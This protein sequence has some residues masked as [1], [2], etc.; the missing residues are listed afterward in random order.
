MVYFLNREGVLAYGIVVGGVSGFAAVKFGESIG[1]NAGEIFS[2]LCIYQTSNSI[3]FF[4]IHKHYP[5]RTPTISRELIVLLLA[6][7]FYI[8]FTPLFAYGYTFLAHKNNI[9]LLA[10][11][12]Q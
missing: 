3:I 8:V 5:Y 1:N 2:F 9:W 4:I 11:I 12:A 10:H 6:T 7:R